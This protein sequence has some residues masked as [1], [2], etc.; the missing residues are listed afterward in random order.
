[1]AKAKAG[2]KVTPV[3]RRRRS[4]S[5]EDLAVLIGEKPLDD[6]AELAELL[7]KQKPWAADFLQHR[8][9]VRTV[10]APDVPVATGPAETEGG[11]NISVTPVDLDGGETRQQ[12]ID[13]I[14]GAGVG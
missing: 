12:Q 14:S 4:V 5:T 11:P 7:K 9:K 2:K 1:M 8:L 10:V 3:K 6:L 13:R